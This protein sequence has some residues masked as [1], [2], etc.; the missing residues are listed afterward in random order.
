MTN[1]KLKALAAELAKDIK[2]PEDLSRLSAHLTKLT[3]EAA[4]NAEI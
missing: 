4:L 3:V 1:D 2:T